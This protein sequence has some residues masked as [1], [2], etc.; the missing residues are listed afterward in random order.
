MTQEHSFN[1]RLSLMNK[2][3]FALTVLA[4]MLLYINLHVGDL[5]GYDDAYHADEARAML[6]SGDYWTVRHNGIYN[7]EFPPLFYWIEALSF[8]VFG[9]TDFAARFPSPLFAVA[10]IIATYFIAYELTGQIWLALVSMVV[11]ITSQ[12]FMKYATH[13]MT[14]ATY[15]FFFS[16]AIL[17]YLK[18]F[19]QPRFYWLCGL[20]I[21]LSLLTRPFVGLVMPAIFFTHLLWSRRK[22]LIWSPYV[23]SGLGLA[24]LFPALWYVIQYRLH[25]DRGLDGPSALMFAQLAAHKMPEFK[26]VLWKVVK[27]IAHFMAL[28]LPWLPLMIFGLIK[29]TGKAFR[30]R[31]SAAMLLVAW[32]AWIFIPFAVSEAGQLRYAM[33][34][35]PAF[36]VLAAMPISKWIP[37]Q[38][39]KFYLNRFY[40]LGLAGVVFMHFIPGSFVL[41]RLIPKPS[42]TVASL[43]RL[44]PGKLMRAEDMR[45]LAPM[46]KAHSRPDQRVIFYA[47]GRPQWNYQS[48]LIWYADR[49]TEMP[50]T[51][52]G[53]LS[54]MKADPEAPVVMDRKSF[55]EFERWAGSALRINLLGESKQYCCFI[56]KGP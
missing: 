33:P 30:Q 51:F 19:R 46:V 5:S 17:F 49:C 23:L 45:T 16:M 53:V 12:F 21:G 3:F 13:A 26:I 9:V 7:P 50:T 56:A 20:A 28:Y 6:K 41:A 43:M 34:I 14:D 55:S 47:E 37:A 27:F 35:F 1:E 8:K 11:M 54:L 39:A 48:Q 36:A 15:V 44:I 42:K 38:K 4:L 24:L 2:H 40:A 31:D 29:Q 52:D 18:A 32:V 10:T 22:A 25:G